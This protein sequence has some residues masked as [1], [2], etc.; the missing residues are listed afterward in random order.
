MTIQK[1]FFCVG[2]MS[3]VGPGLTRPTLLSS[4][5]TL[6]LAE[7]DAPTHVGVSFPVVLVCEGY[8]DIPDGPG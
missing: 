6:A 3:D 1:R 4:N 8:K 2:M 7:A 5:A